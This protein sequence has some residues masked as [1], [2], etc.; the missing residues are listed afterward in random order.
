[1]VFVLPKRLRPYFQW[2]RKLLGD[3]ARIAARTATDFVRATLNE[4]ALSVGIA[5]C[6]ETHGS[7]LNWQPHIHALVTDGGFRPD[8]SFVPLPAHTTDALTEA[9]RR[10]VLRLFVERELLEPEVAESML[11]WPHAG[12]SVHDGVWLDQDD[13]AAHERLARYCARC[14]VSLERLEYDAETG[15]VTYTSDKADGPTAGRHTFEVTD[16]IARL[17]AHIPDKGQVLQRYYGYYANRARGERRKAA[18]APEAEPAAAEI[19]A[20]TSRGLEPALAEA[21]TVEPANVSRADARRWA[22]LIRRIYEVDPLVCPKCGGT[23]RMIALIQEP[24]VVDKILKHLR[25]KGRDA[26]AGPWA[27]GP[28]ADA[29][30]AAAA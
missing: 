13:A 9:F 21:A 25:T 12:F 22:V 3:L 1:M 11:A 10:H 15:T 23:M 26:R 8:G 27:T 29:A 24:K 5:L 7:L 2:R 20:A 6:I 16:F 17:V 19:D 14:P 4:P 28:P 18:R 30:A